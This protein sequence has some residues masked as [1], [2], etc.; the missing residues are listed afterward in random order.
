MGYQGSNNPF[1]GPDQGKPD[2]GKAGQHKHLKGAIKRRLGKKKNAGVML[3][4]NPKKT[5]PGLGPGAK[6]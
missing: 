1:F 4:G 2:H 5:Y 6:R 3:K